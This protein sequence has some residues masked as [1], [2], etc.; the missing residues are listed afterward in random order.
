MDNVILAFQEVIQLQTILAIIGGNIFGL[1]VGCIPGLTI[2]VGMVF[3]L[4]ATFLMP[5]QVAI[6]LLLGMYVSGMTAGSIS[7]I[8]LNMPGT[9]SA[10]A[11][12]I[13]GHEM[14][15]KGEA[16]RALGS[17]IFGSFFGG[18]ISFTALI[19]ISPLIAN[20]ALRFGAVELFSLLLLGLA[21]I[22]SFG[23]GS[24]KAINKAIIATIIGLILTTV[25]YDMQTGI[26]RFTFDVSRLN[27]GF[28]I[29]PVMI[30]LF[31]LPPIIDGVGKET[32]DK[33]SKMYK[34]GV[35]ASL[36]T[37]E[38]IKKFPKYIAMSGV[39]GTIVGAIPGAGGPIAVFL[40]YDY[41]KK[42]AP[43]DRKKLFGTGIPEAIAAP[44]A[45]NNAISG[46]ALIPAFTLGIPGD[47]ITAVLLGALMLQGLTPGPMLFDQNPVLIY[48][49]FISLFIANFTNVAVILLVMKGLIQVLRVPTKYM[50][51]VISGFCVIGSF[52][53]RNNPMDIFSMIGCGILAYFMNK[54]DY[55]IIP[56]LLAVVLGGPMEEHLRM[57]LR[58]NPGNPYVFFTSPI[59]LGFLLLAGLT[60][61]VPIVTGE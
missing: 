30:G 38:D 57:A 2:T 45:A 27:Q 8:L 36:P 46:G 18:L 53:L 29:L 59:S 39:V 15:K 51:T 14:A 54:F 48:G 33:Y 17:A 31:A 21:L 19:F 13:D 60:F 55:P 35:T 3:M 41:S 6:S 61:V 16:G 40:S 56:L 32:K 25:G 52:A 12:G 58:L 37:L 47:P 50:L 9:P 44:E 26:P 4:P 34:S 20:I 49:S 23:R 42:I 5:T 10:S 22:S 43:K 7:A 1:I 28:H 24:G 11:T